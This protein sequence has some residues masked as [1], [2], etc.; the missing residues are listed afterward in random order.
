MNIRWKIKWWDWENN[1]IMR[2]IIII[3]MNEIIKNYNK[4]LVMRDKIK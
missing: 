4:M 2:S 1:K 3:I